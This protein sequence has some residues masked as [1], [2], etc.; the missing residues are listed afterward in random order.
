MFEK[1][2]KIG[3]RSTKAILD[4]KGQQKSYMPDK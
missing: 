1:A 2:L 3:K 4:K